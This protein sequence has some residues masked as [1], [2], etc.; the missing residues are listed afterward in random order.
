MINHGGLMGTIGRLVWAGAFAAGVC[1]AGSAEAVDWSSWVK[2]AGVSSSATLED[3]KAASGIRE[4]LRVGVDK[5]IE[6]TSKK[7]GYFSNE[8]I[9]ILMPER[10]RMTEGLLRK[11]GAGPKIDEFILAMNRSAEAAAPHARDIFIDAIMKMSIQD[12]EALL[13]GGDTA[14]TDYFRKATSSRLTQL[15]RPI[16][17]KAMSKNAVAQQYH[18]VAGRYQA[19]PMASKMPLPSIEDYTVQKALDGLFVVLGQQEKEIRQN[20]QARAT[21]LLQEVFGGGS[22]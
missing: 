20:P 5:A 16:V 18:F 3:T 2:R 9:K 13:K 11:I 14:A 21:A 19:M 7:D 17:E 15:Y 12:A 22:R 10:L 6:L 4:A 1:A 8:R